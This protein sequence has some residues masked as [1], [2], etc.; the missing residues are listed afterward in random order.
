MNLFSDSEQTGEMNQLS[1]QG[2]SLAN[3]THQQ[4]S[5][6]VR[7]MN[8]TCGPK[9]LESFGRFSRNGSWARMFSAL[10]IGME[11]W[12]SMRCRLT[13]KVKG[14]KYNRIYFQLV[15]STLRT[16]EI[17]YGLL[18]TVTAMDSTGSTANMKSTQVKEGS[19][20]SVTLSRALPMGLLPTPR[21]NEVKGCDLNS[22]NLAGRNKGN[23]E[24]TVA[25]WVIGLLPTPSVADTEGGPKRA[26]QIT[27]GDS[28]S[29]Y[30][31]SDTTGTRFGAKLNDV[32]RLLKTPSAMDA[33]SENLS[34]KEQKLGNSGTLAQEIQSGFVYQRGMLPTQQDSNEPTGKT[35]QLNPQFVEEMMGF[36]T[37]WTLM[38]FLKSQEEGQ[39]EVT[40]SKNQ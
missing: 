8:A 33:Y 16:A 12:S 10:L 15:P 4:E 39:P 36:P 19:M 14:T 37:Y 1:S 20:H 22:D 7:M 13:W 21:A 11:G 40:G 17:G 26:D 27:Q 2:D 32:V 5:G 24:E 38:P 31:T 34:K 28:G 3:P 6:R 35:S 29:W 30:R 9:C 18:P 23:L 25:K